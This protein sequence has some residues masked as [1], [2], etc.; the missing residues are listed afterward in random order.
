M[1]LASAAPLGLRRGTHRPAIECSHLERRRLSYTSLR[2]HSCS[3]KGEYPPLACSL[4]ARITRTHPSLP[5]RVAADRARL[6]QQPRSPLHK[7][8]HHIGHQR[9]FARR[10]SHVCAAQAPSSAR[11][12]RPAHPSRGAR[13]W[14]GML[15]PARPARAVAFQGPDRA[16][17]APVCSERLGEGVGGGVRPAVGPRRPQAWHTHRTWCARLF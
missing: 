7:H 14:G 5:L 1:R 2:R 12:N 9:R 4:H 8:A 17:I 11:R 6:A 10:S 13:H 3:T 15:A 16:R